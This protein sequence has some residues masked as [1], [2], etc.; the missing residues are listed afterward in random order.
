LPDQIAV[1]LPKLTEQVFEAAQGE[2]G[3]ADKG[4]Q[5]PAIDPIGCGA[6]RPSQRPKRDR[7]GERKG[8]TC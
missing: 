8:Q 1:K 6:H 7:R 2:I 5:Q 3:S 4:T